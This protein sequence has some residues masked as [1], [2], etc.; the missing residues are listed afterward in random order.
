LENLG[1]VK[2]AAWR[3]DIQMGVLVE[4]LFIGIVDACKTLV[5]T[6]PHTDPHR[7]NNILMG[8]PQWQ[9]IMVSRCILQ[10]LLVK[11]K[12]KTSLLNFEQ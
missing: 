10:L 7:F 12:V 8:T 11:I 6:F 5:K 4:T 3:E 1:A 2:H 9:A